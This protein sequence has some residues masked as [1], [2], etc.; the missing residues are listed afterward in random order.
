MVA[1]KEKDPLANTFN[2]K[3]EISKESTRAL[4]S[5]LKERIQRDK[6]IEKKFFSKKS[7]E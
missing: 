1:M 6:E 3:V 2:F 7:R 5:Y 4:C